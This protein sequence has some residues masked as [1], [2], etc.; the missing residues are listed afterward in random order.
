MIIRI[1]MLIL[2]LVTQQF[3]TRK[4]ITIFNCRNDAELFKLQ[5]H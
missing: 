4:T 2:L 3:Q 1:I 5:I